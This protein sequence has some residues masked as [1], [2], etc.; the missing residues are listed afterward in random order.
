MKVLLTN[1]DGFDAEGMQRFYDELSK[2]H[3]CF[4]VAPDQG[5]SC[6]GHAVTTG[7]ELEVVQQH[8]RAWTVTGTPADCVRMGLL[9]LQLRPDLVVSGVNQGGNLGLDIVYSGTVAAAREACSLGFPA[10]AMSQYMRR[11]VPRDWSA[12]GRRAVFVLEKL[13]ERSDFAPGFW[14]VN[15]P[16]LLPEQHE[17]SFPITECQPEKQPLAFDFQLHPQQEEVEGLS[18]KDDMP[19]RDTIA[20]GRTSR[21]IYKSNYQ[22]RPRQNG[23]DVDLCFEG[24][25]TCSRLRI[26]DFLVM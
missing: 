6:C 10:V 24:H 9:W 22:M 14:N 3:D 20:R 23:S 5:R 25:A 17:L 12:T 16:V 7:S 15:L 13:L 4:I 19:A 11:D 1:D 8:D 2:R 18:A 26:G 21:V